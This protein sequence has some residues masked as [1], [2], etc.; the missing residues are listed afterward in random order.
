MKTET[1]KIA[2]GS[3]VF[4]VIFYLTAKILDYFLF[5]SLLYPV[6][7]GFTAGAE[8]GFW[9]ANKKITLEVH[10]KTLHFFIFMPKNIFFWIK[11]F[12]QKNIFNLILFFTALL[13]I[14]FLAIISFHQ[15]KELYILSSGI[16]QGLI[17]NFF[18]LSLVIVYIALLSFAV[19]IIADSI[20]ITYNFAS[21]L[22]Y[23]FSLAV[24][25]I[26][27]PLLAFCLTGIF[28][29]L[30]ILLPTLIF[31]LKFIGIVFLQYIG[32]FI[33]FAVL[34]LATYSKLFSVAIGGVFGAFCGYLMPGW[35]EW[36][37]TPT[38]EAMAVCVVIGAITG[39]LANKIGQSQLIVIPS[40]L[41]TANKLKI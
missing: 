36:I 25:I 18:S 34:R 13:L 27:S 2:I 28:L 11:S 19:G 6:I 22:K 32:L 24:A 5:E 1:K 31:V 26:L 37:I 21:S 9:T 3:G 15:I 8:T 38:I 17:K 35:N 20:T 30:S 29:L 14:F 7:F 41:M 4:A 16:K 40:H 12:L 23:T 10:K 33:L 39:V